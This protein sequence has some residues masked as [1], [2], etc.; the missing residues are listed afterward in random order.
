MEGIVVD[1]R[2]GYFD[3]FTGNSWLCG[4]KTGFYSLRYEFI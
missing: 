1:L 4:V 2:D 3:L